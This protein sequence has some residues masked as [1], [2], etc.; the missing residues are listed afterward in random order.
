MSFSKAPLFELPRPSGRGARM[1]ISFIGLSQTIIWAKAQ[2][3]FLIFHPH[4]EGRGN[5]NP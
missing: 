1:I 4:P 5:L 3:L 2:F